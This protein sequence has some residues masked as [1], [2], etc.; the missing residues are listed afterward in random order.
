[1]LYHIF[2]IEYQS[3]GKASMVENIKEIRD[4]VDENNIEDENNDASEMELGNFIF[5]NSRGPIRFP[6]EYG[7]EEWTTLTYEKMGVEDYHCTL[8]EWCDDE[9]GHAVKRTNGLVAES[10]GGYICRDENGE[11]VFEIFPYYWDGE[12]TCGAEEENEHLEEKLLKEMFTKSEMKTLKASIPIC[13]DE[14]PASEWVDSANF[15]KPIEE[16]VEI[17]TCGQR[18]KERK[19]LAKKK[20]LSERV[21]QF[22]QKYEELCVAH[23]DGC[24]LCKHNFH[25]HKGQSDEFWIEWYKYPFRDSYCNRKITKEEFRDILK[26]CIVA[27]ENDIKRKKENA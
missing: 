19:I 9:N 18:E 23:K 14:C 17:C 1:M 16:L 6:R 15:D 8:G 26:D 27:V 22:E 3:K 5:G 2:S 20:A 24:L 12:C 4:M 13:D 25:Y 10:T 11:I 7:I 21:Q